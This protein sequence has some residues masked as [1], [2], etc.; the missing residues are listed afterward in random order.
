MENLQKLIEFIIGEILVAMLSV[1][2][3]ITGVYKTESFHPSI[4]G[5]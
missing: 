4:N 1:V 2:A 3:K 5:Y